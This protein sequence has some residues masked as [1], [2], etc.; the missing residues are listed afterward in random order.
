MPV[1]HQQKPVIIFSTIA[2]IAIIVV[3]FLLNRLTSEDPKTQDQAPD[4]QQSS[5]TDNGSDSISLMVDGKDVNSAL[6]GTTES[7]EELVGKIS[8]I[9]IQANS[10]GDIQPFIQFV[11]EK[12]LS[13]IQ[14]THLHNL[15]SDSRLKLNQ[16]T[17]FSALQDPG[18]HW[19]LNLENQKRILLQ[20]GKK[21]DGTWKVKGLTLPKPDLSPK[22][23]TEIPAE[24][25]PNQ[26]RTQ[27]RAAVQGFLKAILQLDPTAASAYLEP[28]QVSY[29][30]LAGLCILFEEGGYQL[31]EEKPIRN[32]FL[33][34]NTAGWITRVEAKD[35]QKSAIF[36]LSTKRKDPQSAWKI[37][38]INLDKLLTEYASRLGGGDIHYIPLVKTPEGGDS[39]VLYFDLDS[40]K[41][42]NRTQK[43]LQIIATLL[44]SSDEKKLT[45]SG[46]TDA[47]GSDDYNLNLSD[48]RAKQVMSFLASQG[49]ASKQMII[50]S[51]GKSKPRRPNSTDDGRRA[52]RRAE[53]LLDF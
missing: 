32:M 20:L 28:N 41:L 51:H 26:E 14:I 24:T 34:N 52:N 16:T 38:E 19:A 29:A 25:D 44:K 35:A 53:I 9:M 27:A 10:T 31:A 50:T 37:T 30:T 21:K 45:I 36:A 6:T 49:V 48:Q 13:P 2:V 23:N 40:N 22:P 15:A 42:S 33:S 17:P 1:S 3:V 8:E 18:H 43:Q 7:A 5:E 4:S 47:L 11:G 12:N 46:H 39:I